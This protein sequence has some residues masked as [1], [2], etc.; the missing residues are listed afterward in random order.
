MG[1]ATTQDTY[2]HTPSHTRIREMT[3]SDL[4]VLDDDFYS[5]REEGR[6][7]DTIYL[8]SS[9]FIHQSIPATFSFACRIT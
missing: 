7:E 2:K 4:S 1:K 8:I 9:S 5:Q 3:F 6:K